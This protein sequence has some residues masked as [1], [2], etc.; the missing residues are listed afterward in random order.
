MKVMPGFT[1]RN[2]RGLSLQL[3]IISAFGMPAAPLFAAQAEEGGNQLPAVTVSASEEGSTAQQEKGYRNKKQATSGFT[4]QSVLDTPYSVTSLP[5]ELMRDQQAKSLV[6]VTK[7]DPSVSRANSPLWYDRVNIRGFY[8]GVDAIQ[9]D[10]LSIN[11]QGHIALE[12][13]AA[14]EIA[15]GLSAMRYGATSP[16]GVVNYVIKRPT[17]EP[18]SRVTVSADGFGSKGAHV[19]LGGRFGDTEEYGVRVNV[20]KEDIQT[21]I[22]EVTADKKFF[23]TAFDWRMSDRL[24]LEMDVERNERVSVDPSTPSLWWFD[25]LDEARAFY[26]N[27]DAETFAGATWAKEPNY[28]TYY[29]GRLTYAINDQWS[30]RLSAQQAEL[31]RSQESVSPGSVQ[32]D[33]SYDAWLYFSPDQR[34]TNDAFQAV[35]EGGFNTGAIQHALAF[36]M[37]TLQREMTYPDGFYDVIGTGN[38]F[39]ATPISQVRVSSDP[40]YLANRLK[41]DSIF[42]TDTL[43]FNDLFQVFGGLRETSLRNYSGG[44][45][46]ALSKGYEES[47]LTPAAG[48]V[49]KPQPKTSFYLSYAEGIEQGGT[50]PLEATNV[51]EV[52]EPLKSE[53]IEAGIKQEVG[54]NALLTAAVFQIDKG[55]ELINGAGRYVQDGRQVHEGVEFTASGELAPGLRLIGGVAWLDAEIGKNSDPAL[56]GKRPPNVAEWQGNLFA[57]YSLESV[58]AGLSINGGVYYSD[59]K[60]IDDLNTWMADSWTRVDAGVRLTRPLNRDTQATYRLNVENL[61]DE[62]YLANTQWGSL[63]FGAPLTVKASA[64]FDF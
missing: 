60:A 42:I 8:L 33:G 57:D 21:Y 55:L 53:Q 1:Y 51:G 2:P 58:M 3:A 56:N 20:A 7:N 22:D 4:E 5:N 14:V 17:D 50:A 52:L 19:D 32:P 29:A 11:D 39:A 41:Q 26:R 59:D 37:D 16:G 30:A 10:G 13:K 62:R 18:L 47:A 15:K 63:D 48:V 31:I 28:Q 43:S 9:R 45:G 44:P 46:V 27:L 40:S 64:E 54:A 12:N 23:S 36:G 49:F 34:R 38:L 25:S 24:L 61:T 35:I 6:D